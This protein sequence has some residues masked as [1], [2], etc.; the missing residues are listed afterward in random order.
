MKKID[1]K[2]ILSP[3]ELLVGIII[4]T[5]LML[6]LFVEDITIRMVGLSVSVLGLI[7]LFWLMSNKQDSSE[8]KP[9]NKLFQTLDSFASKIITTKRDEKGDFVASFGKENDKSDKKVPNVKFYDKNPLDDVP[10]E[11]EESDIDGFRVVPKGGNPKETKT[12]PKPIKTEAPVKPV[13]KKPEPVIIEEF[14]F[15]DEE[16]GMRIIPKEQSTISDKKP[17]II[18]VNASE[19]APVFRKTEPII[20]EDEFEEDAEPE[21]ILRKEEKSDGSAVTL[22]LDEDIVQEVI[23]ENIF[24]SAEFSKLYRKKQIDIPIT[25]LMEDEPYTTKETREEFDYFILRVLRAIRTYIKAKSSAFLLINKTKKELILEVIDS[26]IEESLIPKRKITIRND[27]LSQIA[28]SAK[29]EILTEIN[30]NAELEI[31]PYYQEFVGTNSFI[32]VPVFYNKAIVG[33]L[34]ADTDKPD[35]Y[36]VDTIRFFSQFTKLISAII[37]NYTEKYDLIQSSR[38]LEAIK[39]FRRIMSNQKMSIEDIHISLVESATKLFEYNT[40]GIST[41]NEDTGSWAVKNIRKTDEDS[42]IVDGAKV[43]LDKSIIGEGIISCNTVFKSPLEAADIRINNE[44]PTIDEGYFI[45]V[46]IKSF[47]NNY[48]AIF[49]EGDSNCSFTDY[50]REI[51]ETLGEHAGTSIEQMY[52]IE[53]LQSSSLVDNSTGLYNPPAFYSRLDEEIS[54]IQGYSTAATLCL[55]SI[56]KYAAFEEDSSGERAEQIIY[57]AL[58]VVGKHLRKFDIIGRLDGETFA[59]LIPGMKISQAQLWAEAL[60]T[61]IAQTVIE[62]QSKR[63]NV[64]VS[65][66]LA[67]ISS[68]DTVEELIDSCRHVLNL[69]QKHSNVVQIFG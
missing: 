45:S 54:R 29:P 67:K 63:F 69:A 38:T 19:K 28:K 62:L 12:E 50:D 7:G 58:N 44:E 18:S 21:I 23:E 34:C 65:I 31:I 43:E 24:E 52:F 64:T 49:L 57:Q 9:K 10:D 48:G 36:D 68:S 39:L 22:N 14:E 51:L 59:I 47:V 60:R 8:E 26:D 13:Y 25:M 11:F 61:E 30:P 27:V 20:I 17:E 5:G 66:G 46:P 40:A 37:Q 42:K 33:I 55:F 15:E 32:G 1:I 2:K 6:A 35:A 41:Y 16:S 3:G 53:M 56:D 4:L